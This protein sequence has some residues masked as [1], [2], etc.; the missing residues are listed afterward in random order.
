MG[1]LHPLAAGTALLALGVKAQFSYQGC[2]AL[3]TSTIKNTTELYPQGPAAC[4][5]YCN[6]IGMPKGYSYAG[7]QAQ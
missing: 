3:D 7:I 4:L 2:A 5:S 6:S 1:R